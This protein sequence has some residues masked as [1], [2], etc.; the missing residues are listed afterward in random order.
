MKR[1]RLISEQDFLTLQSIKANDS[2]LS[3]DTG[4]AP[5]YKS[6][7]TNKAISTLLN[8][9]LPSDVKLRVYN[10]LTKRIK[11]EDKRNNEKPL[12]VKLSNEMES[13]NFP[14]PIH[15]NHSKPKVTSITLP[16]GMTTIP[17]KFQPKFNS[18]MEIIKNNKEK[19]SWD[20]EGQFIRNGVVIKQSNV[21][22]LLNTVIR[23]L[24]PHAPL[25]GHS[26]FMQTLS[27]MN[28]PKTLLSKQAQKNI[29]TKTQ[30]RQSRLSNSRNDTAPISQLYGEESMGE[31]EE[32]TTGPSTQEPS[33]SSGWKSW[34]Y[35]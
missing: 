15:N 11:S 13:N 34:I 1:M 21:T 35:L 8:D 7:L 4:F 33:T 9:N 31:D 29:L 32:S 2:Q 22:D 6:S 28:V 18:M 12:L 10:N 17:P 27:D 14:T 3:T 26:E 23:G 5:D 19:F 20:R 25:I 16:P 24:K 30:R